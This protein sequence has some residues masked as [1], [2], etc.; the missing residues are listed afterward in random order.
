MELTS[1]SANCFASLVDISLVASR[2][3]ISLCLYLVNVFVVS[4]IKVTNNVL[5][6]YAQTRHKYL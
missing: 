6:R 5:F 3:L 2:L 4:S 1:I